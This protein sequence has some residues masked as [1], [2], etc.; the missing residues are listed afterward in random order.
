MYY[1]VRPLAWIIALVFI[2]LYGTYEAILFII[3]LL[4]KAVLELED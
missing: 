1:L 3:R 4:K 2:T